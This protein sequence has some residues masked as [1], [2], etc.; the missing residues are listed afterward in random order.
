MKTEPPE[1]IISAVRKILKGDIYVSDQ[2]Q[3]NI[4]SNYYHMQSEVDISPVNSLSNRELEVLQLIGQGLK[5][6][7]IADELNLSVKTIETHT[8]RIKKKLNLRHTRE[9]LMHAVQLSV[10]DYLK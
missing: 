2:V 8:E 5:N 1:K 10:N 9:V 4:F 6:K 7:K 3:D